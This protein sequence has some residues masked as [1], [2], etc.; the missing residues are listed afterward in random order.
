[1]HPQQKHARFNLIVTLSAAIP[2]VLGYAILLP[3]VGPKRAI[4]ALAFM[5]VCALWGFGNHFYRKQKDS[6]TVTMDERDEDIKRRAIVIAWAVDWLFWGLLCMV[7]WFVVAFR[8]GLEQTQVPMIPVF[9]LPLV[10]M[11]IAWV[12]MSAW[13]TAVLVLYGKGADNDGE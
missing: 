2:S 13:S 1:M 7:P 6:P 8:F 11:A 4:A 9:C 12:H 10:Y 5:G 3:Y